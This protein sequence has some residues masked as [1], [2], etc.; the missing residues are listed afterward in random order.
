MIIIAHLFIFNYL[1]TKVCLYERFQN[2]MPSTLILSEPSLDRA[3]RISAL[4]VY[5]ANVSNADLVCYQC[6]VS[7]I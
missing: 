7:N 1:Y 4:N 5:V 6:K 2:C 3:T